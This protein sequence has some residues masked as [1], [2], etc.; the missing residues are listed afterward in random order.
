MDTNALE[1][2]LK[3]LGKTQS[4]LA[5]HLG[6]DPAR[7][8]EIKQGR[9]AIRFEEALEIADF[10]MVGHEQIAAWF[11]LQLDAPKPSK[12]MVVGYVGAGD[13]VYPIDDHAAGAGHYEVDAPPGAEGD[14]SVVVR[15][16]SMTPR[17]RDGEH[18]GYSRELGFNLQNCYGRECVVDLVDGRRLVKIIERSNNDGCVSLVSVNGATPTEYDMPVNWVAPVTWVV[19]RP[20]TR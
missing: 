6:I 15:G 12:T 9:R 14:V 5:E 7:I 11:G 2:R 19:L 10:L 18:L 20:R 17:F 4:Q 16:D 1:R 3:E 8:T 13:A